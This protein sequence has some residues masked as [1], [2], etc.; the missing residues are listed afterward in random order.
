MFAMYLLET[1]I[2]VHVCVYIY[3]YIYMYIRIYLYMY[4]HPCIYQSYIVI[5]CVHLGGGIPAFAF[6]KHYCFGVIAPVEHKFV[7]GPVWPKE[8]EGGRK[9]RRKEH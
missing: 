6:G 4:I 3:I 5:S 8:E 9:G 1:N 2:P 7:H